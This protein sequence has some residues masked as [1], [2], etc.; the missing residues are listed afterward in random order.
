[1]IVS[2]SHLSPRAARA[3]VFAL[4]LTGFSLGLPYLPM[5]SLGPQKSAA[6]EAAPTASSYLDQIYAVARGYL[7]GPQRDPAKAAS[8]F[9]Q[10]AKVGD[11]R[12]LI[13]LADLYLR[14]DG[15]EADPGHAK[16]LLES[17]I[18]A[19]ATKDGW[20]A[21]ADL[22]HAEGPYRSDGNERDALEHAAEL[23]DQSSMIRLGQM[24]GA[25]IGGD[26]NF[27]RAR[28]LLA[29][30][31]AIGGDHIA[32]AW[33]ALGDLYNNAEAANRDAAKAA[34]A[35]QQASSLGHV[36]ST[37]S[38]ANLVSAG[39][40]VPKDFERA[41]SLLEGA[42]SQGGEK[43]VMGWV[44]LGELYLKPG[45]VDRDPTKAVDAYQRAADLGD[46]SS[47][48]RLAQIVG[49]GKEVPV[50]VGRAAAAL[51]KAAAID[52]TEAPRAWSLLGD[53]YA[54]AAAPDHN[55]AK[56]VEAYQKAADLGD[57]RSMI[58]IAKIVGRGEGVPKDFGR[59]AAALEAVIAIGGDRATTAWAN[60]GQLYERADPPN[61]DLVKAADA[62]GKAADLGDPWS[63]IALAQILAAGEA[64]PADP[65]RARDLLQKA[66]AVG[67]ESTSKAWATLGELYRDA[68]API[69]NRSLAVDAYQHAVD[70]GD[71]R[72]SA[73]SLAR[74][75]GN[76]DG[77][78]ADFDRAKN[79]LNR[80]I[81]A[82]GD[83][84]RYA[85]A[86]FG[87]LYG[88]D[89]RPWHDA[90]KAAEA[91]QAAADL[92]DPWSMISLAKLKAAGGEIPLD[93]A[94]AMAL[95]EKAIAAG[96]RNISA[97]AWAG[98]GDLYRDSGDPANAAD[99]Y[100][101]AVDNGDRWSA[102]GLARIV[103]KGDGVA[104]DFDKAAALLNSVTDA[105]DDVAASAWSTF[106]QLYLADGKPWRSPAKA[107]DAYQH[108]SALGDPW[109]TMAVA[110]LIATGVGVPGDISQATRLLHELATNNPDSEVA[111]SAYGQVGDL[112]YFAEA[113]DRDPAKAVE[114]Y[115]K[116]A[117]LG[118]SASMVQLGI[119]LSNGDGVP[120]D[121]DRAKSL[122]EKASLD[123]S[124]AGE[125]WA[126]LGD[127]YRNADISRQ[128]IALALENY[129]RA[130]AAGI[131][132]AHLAVAEINGAT[133]ETAEERT[134]VAR[135]LLAAAA[136]L[137]P[138]QVGKA[139]F[140]L[141]PTVL[142]AVV[143][144]MLSNAGYP[145]GSVDGVLGRQTQRS[146]NSFCEAKQINSCSDGIITL[147]LVK[148]LL[149]AKG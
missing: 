123:A 69:G 87:Q 27:D 6:A 127:L 126:S 142:Y 100:Q 130:A 93:R 146:L 105:N 25:G 52:E 94:G 113:P 140:N 97:R 109:A 144:E 45:L 34:D 119:M 98:V 135:H 64:L 32:I 117:A 42:V 125:A 128:D 29:E 56:A 43:A 129:E 96:D 59:A 37:I 23:K 2:L 53:L 8:L 90:V 10:A 143:Q 7:D 138:D 86:L 49:W 102:I 55:P 122:F 104:V 103:G 61:Q 74:L 82:G 18:A 67:G 120:A 41:I 110:R 44:G 91:Y 13:A 68:P 81:S 70:A 19:G 107:L 26:R 66:V 112:Y 118:R 84:V 145:P 92:G 16:E 14:G 106:G 54:E 5:G 48:I 149:T 133:A 17:A 85:W 47:L 115:E 83:H 137:G 75:V 51:E 147:D 139:M 65:K 99:A 124:A 21:L 101:K 30:A 36:P 77:V 72:W 108:A 33:G 39:D 60:L 62:Y 111:A 12:S 38:L 121:F 131:G 3:S 141:S 50:N 31:I 95:L 114:A 4:A 9:D 1:M 80:S 88:D 24:L 20:A 11:T 15:V 22:Y 28:S 134:A 71:N 58:E 40:G 116:S 148:G 136:Q 35:Y 89:E 78:P 57:Q 63:M 76:G 46:T 73:I 132:R 79:L